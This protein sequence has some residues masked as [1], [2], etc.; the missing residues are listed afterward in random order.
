M[1][2]L[3]NIIREMLLFNIINEKL[4]FGALRLWQSFFTFFFF[5][6]DFTSFCV[7]FVNLAVNNCLI[8]CVEILFLLAGA[9][10]ALFSLLSFPF[11]LIPATFG[12]YS[13]VRKSDA[14]PI[15]KQ[16]VCR[17]AKHPGNL[18]WEGFK[19][20]PETN[21]FCLLEKHTSLSYYSTLFTLTHYSPI[22][23]F[24]LLLHT[25]AWLTTD[26]QGRFLLKLLSSSIFSTLTFWSQDLTIVCHG[27][28]QL[29][30]QL[31]SSCNAPLCLQK[32]G[33]TALCFAP[34]RVFGVWHAQRSHPYAF[35]NTSLIRAV[36]A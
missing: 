15:P 1:C 29:P 32:H 25:L 24:T 14:A 8:L 11:F 6:R 13:P 17:N 31:L 23:L 12:L 20:S 36:H 2:L 22:C 18:Y 7:K 30:T 16:F 35:P 10:C 9:L 28:A 34:T 5:V 4:L 3:F 21:P 26:C 27:Q 19:R 33:P